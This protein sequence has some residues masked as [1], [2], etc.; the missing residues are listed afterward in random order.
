[1]SNNKKYLFKAISLKIMEN[2]KTNF[3]YKFKIL[4][5]NICDQSRINEND[6]KKKPV[7]LELGTNWLF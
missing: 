5:M 1:M 6:R 7:S 4:Q 3:V 2:L